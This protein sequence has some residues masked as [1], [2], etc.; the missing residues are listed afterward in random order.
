MTQKSGK[1]FTKLLWIVFVVGVGVSG[2]VFATLLQRE[3]EEQVAAKSALFLETMNSVRDFTSSEVK[4]LFDSE[5]NEHFHPPSLAS[6]AARKVFESVNRREEYRELSYRQATL[7][8]F[9]PEAKANAFETTLIQYFRSNPTVDESRGFHAASGKKLFFIARPIVVNKA[10]CL[11]C[12]ST[13]AAA[14]KSVTSRYGLVHGYGW[15]LGG[16]P[17]VQVVYMPAETPLKSAIEVFI[18]F[19]LAASGILGTILLVIHFLFVRVTAASQKLDQLK[20]DFL[21]AVSHE[22]RAP[23]ANIKL[24]TKMLQK[25]VTPEQ[26]ERYLQILTSECARET[27]LINDLLDLQRAEDDEQSLHLETIVFA[28]WLP[29]LIEPFRF[30]TEQNQQILQMSIDPATAPL[31]SNRN[32]LQRITTELVNNACKY[33]PAGGS[34]LVEIRPAADSQQA[35]ELVVCNSGVEIPLADLEQIFERFYRVPGMDTR[36]QGGTGL[37]L[38]LVRKLAR[39]LGGTV[40]VRSQACQTTFVVRLPQPHRSVRHSVLRLLS[41]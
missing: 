30:Y 8:P 2:T 9:N 31:K 35:V 5:L 11:A 17:G 20:E 28:E 14:P 32:S 38:A 15:Q 19:M 12:H 22:L 26:R 25:D 21:S 41:T 36:Q 29:P 34:I 23:M 13:A 40:E 37:G 27:R 7:D 6:Y 18:P 39:Q 10:S 3:A 24:A 4:P 16:I 33:T 1:L